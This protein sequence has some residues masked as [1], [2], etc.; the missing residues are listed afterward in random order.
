MKRKKKKKN[1]P[2][3]KFF[4]LLS[5]RIME[6]NSVMSNKNNKFSRFLLLSPKKINQE[7]EK[8]KNK[9]SRIILQIKS[10]ASKQISW[11]CCRCRFDFSKRLPPFFFFFGF[12]LVLLRFTLHHIHHIHLLSSSQSTAEMIATAEIP[13]PSSLPPASYSGPPSS[14][15]LLSSSHPQPPYQSS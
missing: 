2:Q 1:S 10:P 12:H 3:N 11:C 9:S 14:W 4:A 6:P 7:K 5:C 15:P 8:K 13:H